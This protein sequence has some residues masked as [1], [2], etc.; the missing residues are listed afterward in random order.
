MSR[1]LIPVVA[2]AACA[3]APLGARPSAPLEGAE[4]IT[5]NSDSLPIYKDYLSVFR[6]GFRLDC[7]EGSSASLIFGKDDPRL[8][9]PNRNVYGLANPP[10]GSYFRI[11]VDGDSIRIFRSG[12]SPEDNTSEALAVLPLSL[13]PISEP[14]RQAEIA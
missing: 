3:F 8:M 9:D 13:I 1:K 5:V 10:G 7:P 4:W 12:Y 2:L 11:A 14:P 6:L